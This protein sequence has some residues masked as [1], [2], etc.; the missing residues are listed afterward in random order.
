MNPQE[1]ADSTLPLKRR[2]EDNGSCIATNDR[3]NSSAEDECSGDENS[4]DRWEK[5]KERNREH[6]KKTRLRKKN[7][8]EGLKKRLLEVQ[9]EVQPS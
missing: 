7:M 3:Y 1:Y 9:R 5:N 6:A 8:I 4:S 2:L